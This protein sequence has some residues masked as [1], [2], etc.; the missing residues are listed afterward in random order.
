MNSPQ[1]A[2]EVCLRRLAGLAEFLVT[3]ARLELDA[4]RTC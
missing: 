4:R 1:Q 2:H 3:W